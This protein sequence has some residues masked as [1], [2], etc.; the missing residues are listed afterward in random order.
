[1]TLQN[2]LADNMRVWYQ[3]DKTDP[4][5][6]KKL[7]YGKGGFKPTVV[8]AQYQIKQMT[9][10][11]G[12]IGIGWGISGERIT[13]HEFQPEKEGDKEPPLNTKFIYQAHLWLKDGQGFDFSSDINLMEKTKNGWQLVTDPIKK[14]STDALTK[15]FSRLGL[16]ADIFMGRFDDN[17]YLQE[18]KKEADS[19]RVAHQE[20]EQQARKELER[21]K[22]SAEI[23]RLMS[24]IA[25]HEATLLKYG[26]NAD[27]INLK[28]KAVSPAGNIDDLDKAE[29]K[30]LGFLEGFLNKMQMA[31]VMSETI[32]T[33]KGK[34]K[35]S[36]EGVIATVFDNGNVPLNFESSNP[37]VKLS[38][39][40]LK[41]LQ[42]QLDQIG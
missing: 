32:K 36:A 7:E 34:D 23:N 22:N 1:M 16:A 3:V 39:D 42:H 38:L 41:A 24:L 25:K 31:F 9:E 30:N 11:F 12:P 37:A 35:K 14:V 33:L 8:D 15:A 17:V 19:E 29:L 18:R 2:S 13:T 4:A 6:T 21:S 10:I 26:A 27:D 28:K 40:Q 5:F 20:Q